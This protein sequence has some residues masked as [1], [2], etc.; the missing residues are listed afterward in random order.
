MFLYYS[1]M[2]WTVKI[3]HKKRG[4]FIIGDEGDVV[5]DSTIALL[6][7]SMLLPVLLQAWE[8]V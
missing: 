8:V 5:V 7:S 2:K 4:S 3:A 1:Q 6:I